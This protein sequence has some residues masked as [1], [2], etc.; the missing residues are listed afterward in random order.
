[1]SQAYASSFS[2]ADR[3]FLGSQLA[4]RLSP[5]QAQ[6]SVELAPILKNA[7]SHF[8]K[9]HQAYIAASKGLRKEE[10]D[11]AVAY[12][13]SDMGDSLARDID[14]IFAMI[15]Q[16]KGYIGLHGTEQE[17]GDLQVALDQCVRGQTRRETQSQEQI[18]Q[19]LTHFQEA[20]PRYP[21]LHYKEGSLDLVQHV[22]DT[23]AKRDKST[24]ALVD[25][26]AETKAARIV[27]WNAARDWDRA[28]R[29]LRHVV[30]GI[31]CFLK[32]EPEFSTFFPRQKAPTSAKTQS[33]PADTNTPS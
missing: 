21:I 20:L 4:E 2:K 12:A 33:S 6:L 3:L 14:M 10:E 15:E 28:Y 9:T 1:M 27:F 23:Q 22:Q 30:R 13:N 18:F 32:R 29:G 8:Q 31:L 16:C 26:R 24:Q 25:E 7:D 17:K 11:D 5:L 19:F